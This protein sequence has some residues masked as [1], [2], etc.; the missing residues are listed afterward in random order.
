MQNRVLFE[1]KFGQGNQYDYKANKVYY[2]F[3]QY[4]VQ[5]DKCF[6]FSPI[7]KF[8]TLSINK[9][10]YVMTVDTENDYYDFTV[11]YTLNPSI[12]YVSPQFNNVFDFLNAVD[13]YV[14]F[15]KEWTKETN[16]TIFNEKNEFINCIV[17]IKTGGGL[18]RYSYAKIL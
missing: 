8:C 6:I 17:R 16:H 1:P 12:R 7:N 5:R 4:K 3:R 15:E 9:L 18:D 14:K 13:Y 2:Y 10:K 11:I